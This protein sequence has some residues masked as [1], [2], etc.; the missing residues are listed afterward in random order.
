MV[1]RTYRASG[2]QVRRLRE[3]AR[4]YRPAV[5]MSG[6][7][8]RCIDIGIAQLEADPFAFVPEERR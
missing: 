4:R 8:R 7:V 3:L 6:I 1:V 5:S 2:G